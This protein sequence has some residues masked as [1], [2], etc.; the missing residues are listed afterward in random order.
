VNRP[1]GWAWNKP[2]GCRSGV[3]FGLRLNF[4]EDTLDLVGKLIKVAAMVYGSFHSLL[5]AGLLIDV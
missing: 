2:I 5:P 1:L 3:P 4:D